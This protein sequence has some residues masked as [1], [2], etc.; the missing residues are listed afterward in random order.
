MALGAIPEDKYVEFVCYW[1]EQYHKHIDAELVSTIHHIAEANTYAMQRISHELFDEVSSGEK[2]DRLILTKAVNNIIE[3]E[4]PR[5]ARML[6]HV[7]DRQQNLL[8]AIAKEGRVQK[9]MSAAFLRKYHLASSSAVQNAIKHL[10]ELDLVTQ[11]DKKQYMVEDVF[12][13]LYLNQ[14]SEK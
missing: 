6:S 1:F 12:L 2:A 4:A 8:F 7:P 13:K 11:D 14:I 5:F 9:I 10:I 3:A